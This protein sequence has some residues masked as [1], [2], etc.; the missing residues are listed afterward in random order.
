MVYHSGGGTAIGGL[1][2]GKTY[3]VIATGDTTVA[4]AESQTEALAAA[5]LVFAPHSN[6]LD[7]A[8]KIDFGYNHGLINGQAVV[9][10]SGGGADIGGLTDGEVYYVIRVDD[11]TIQLSIDPTKLTA[12]DAVDLDSSV[13]YGSVHSLH[14]GFDPAS[15]VQATPDTAAATT[16]LIDLGYEHDLLTGQA[17]RY[18]VLSDEAI[19]GLSNGGVYYAIIIDETTVA[20]A[21]SEEDADLGRFRF[22]DVAR[23]VGD[24]HQTIDLRV[25]HGFSNG[26]P[27]VFSTGGAG[28]IGGL[29]DGQTY[30]IIVVDDPNEAVDTGI[31]L[32]ATPGGP[33]I[34]LDTS[35]ASGNSYYVRGDTQSV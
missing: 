12:A 10:D 16:N 19:G 31:K 13:A 17:V 34:T 22:F 32:A 15:A 8:N 1:T 33:A 28:D 6:V 29:A 14:P 18:D 23:D 2:D 21:E 7:E 27:V 25:E 26:D 9:Y 4:L 3:Y 35:G 11:M 30:Y 20:L 5:G 24:D